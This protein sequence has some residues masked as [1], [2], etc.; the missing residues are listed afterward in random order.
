MRKPPLGELELEVLQFISDNSPCTVRD[1]TDSFSKSHGLAR[2]TILT[3]M[4]RLRK[5]GY[6]A[7]RKKDGAFAYTPSH[8]QGEVLQEIVKQFVEKKL[9]G[10]LTPFVAYLTDA[11]G[12]TPSEVD[13]LRA[14]V[15][16]LDSEDSDAK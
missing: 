5:K 14:M 1:A 9:G 6:L 12:L 8:E 7:R 11:K 13:S 16:D 15:D 3:V 2:T 4:E 10:S